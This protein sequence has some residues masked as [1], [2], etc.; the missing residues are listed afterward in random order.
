M[1]ISSTEALEMT[2]CR[3]LA[4]I[5]AGY[6]GL[7]LGIAFRELGAEVTVIEMADRILPRYDAPLARPVRRWLDRAPIKTTLHLGAKV[8]GLDGEGRLAVETAEQALAADK[9]LVTVGR[10]PAPGL[11]P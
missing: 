1:V 7:E 5:G 8:T 6:I 3:K 11:G 9:I 4:V 10:R 2:D